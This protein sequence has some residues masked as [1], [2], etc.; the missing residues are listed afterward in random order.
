MAEPSVPEF[1]GR[2]VLRRFASQT[3]LEALAGAYQSSVDLMDA[4]C[5]HFYEL[6]RWE[7]GLSDAQPP[8]FP[9]TTLQERVA[10]PLGEPAMLCQRTRLLHDKQ[11]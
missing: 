9:T 11:F 7:A 1:G 3:A 10:R 6:S 8:P 4:Y 5:H 2:R